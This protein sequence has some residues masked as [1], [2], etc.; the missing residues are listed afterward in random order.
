MPEGRRIIEKQIAKAT[1]EG[2]ALDLEA[3]KAAI[4]ATYDDFARDRERVERSMKLMIEE[5]NRLTGDLEAAI[6]AFGLENAGFV[7][8]LENMSHG[9]CIFD[10]PNRLVVANSRYRQIY[11]LSEELTRP[12]VALSRLLR[13]IKGRETS[14]DGKARKKLRSVALGK[15]PGDVLRSEWRLANGAIIEVVATR[16]RDGGIV[17]LH[18]DVTEKRNAQAHIEHLARHDG[19]TGLPNRAMFHEFLELRLSGDARGSAFAVHYIDLDR[20]KTV[21]DSFGHIV[22]DELLRQVANRLRGAIRESDIVARLGG[23]QFALIQ[24]GARDHRAAALAAQRVIDAVGGAFDIEGRQFQIGVSIGVSFAPTDG[25]DADRLMKNADLALHRAK[26]DSRNTFRFFEPGMD[27]NL[28]ERRSLELE[29]RG[30]IENDEFE[31]FYQPLF[32]LRHN[33]ISGFE[34][35][36]RWNSPTR[37]RVS[38]LVVISV[39]EET[40]LITPLGEWVIR[41]ACQEAA[42]W[43]LGLKIAV[44]VSAVQFKNAGLPLVVAGALAESGLSPSRLELEVTE[45]AMLQETEQT[46]NSLV[47]LKNLGV[48]IAMDDFGAGFSSL[49]YLRSF[50]FDKIK[51]DQSFVRDADSDSS[52]RSIIRAVIELGRS[53]G[54]ATTAEGVETIEQ[55]EAVRS[56]GRQEIQGYFIAKPMPAGQIAALLQQSRLLAAASA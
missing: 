27:A 4:A 23:D 39:A 19:L 12:G 16:I 7:P 38:P 28:T 14:R 1:S 54:I 56:E 55:L 46:I 5:N 6:K 33:R 17:T 34:A 2:G 3:L 26:S 35:L 25:D 48:S 10:E 24:F 41:R 36:L 45:S 44:N 32:D 20:F 49:N 21:N 52:A 22:G 53:F 29:L 40:G 50:P 30:A 18:E 11:G 31:L 51:I 8:A 42:K 15:T 13:A 43:P 37:G 9:L 47:Q